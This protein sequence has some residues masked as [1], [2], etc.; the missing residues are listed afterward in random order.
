M[1]QYIHY[2]IYPITICVIL[3]EES[4]N[5]NLDF[6]FMRFNVLISSCVA[7]LASTI[8]A[9]TEAAKD[10]QVT[11]KVFFDVTLGGKPL[12][13]MVIGLFGDVCPKTVKNFVEL[14]VGTGENK[15]MHYRGSSFHRVIKNFMIQGGDFTRQYPLLCP[16][17]E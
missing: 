17:H 1:R 14:A 9:N 8:S 12:G 7:L 2:A 6:S 16:S 4:S 10:P 3:N 13:R 5:Q 15:S 11:E